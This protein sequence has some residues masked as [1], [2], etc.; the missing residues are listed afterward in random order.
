MTYNLDKDAADRRDALRVIRDA[1]P[2][3]VCFQEASREWIEYLRAALSH[4]YP[5][6]VFNQPRIGYDGVGVLSRYPIPRHAILDRAPG[7]WFPSLRFTVD[8]PLGSVEVLNVHLRPPATDGGN[9]LVG[10]FTSPAQRRREVETLVRQLDPALPHIV[11]G[12]FNEGDD[13]SAV[14]FLQ[15]NA[16]LSDSLSQFDRR[17][18]TWKG[19]FAGMS[20]SERADHILYSSELHAFDARALPETASDHDPV[21]A[22]I[23]RERR[24]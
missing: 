6:A 20:L 14:R 10:Y 22:V 1:R 8:S 12:D 13:G 4:E 23:G 3:V 16:R 9:K 5:Y 11:L 24:P 19:R 2:D 18:A 7:G 21:L 17:S 15:T